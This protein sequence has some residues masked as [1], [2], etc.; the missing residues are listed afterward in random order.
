LIFS[1]RVTVKG[2]LFE[3]RTTLDELPPGNE[4]RAVQILES[5]LTELKRV[6]LK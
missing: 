3:I 6:S 5:C 2:L 4:E 1:V